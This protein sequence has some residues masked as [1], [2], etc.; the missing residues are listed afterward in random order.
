MIKLGTH[1]IICTLSV[2][3]ET[4]FK[5]KY[6]TSTSTLIFVNIITDLKKGCFPDLMP[7]SVPCFTRS[8]WTDVMFTYFVSCETG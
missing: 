4:G 2:S 5:I 7:E 1:N 6:Q 3:A 8:L